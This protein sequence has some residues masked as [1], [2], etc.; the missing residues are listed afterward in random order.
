MGCDD[1]GGA[2]GAF[3][4]K[5]RISADIRDGGITARVGDCVGGGDGEDADAA[6]ANGAGDAVTL[7][8]NRDRRSIRGETYTPSNGFVRLCPPN[9]QTQLTPS[10]SIEFVDSSSA[11]VLEHIVVIVRPN[12]DRGSIRGETYTISTFFIG[13]CPQNIRPQLTPTRP[14]EFVDT[15]PAFSGVRISRSP[16]ADVVIIRPNRNHRSIRGKTYTYSTLFILLRPQ[17]IRSQLTP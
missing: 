12:R 17:Y 2:V 16:A 8:P 11:V 4:E 3:D 10:R 1:I 14:I 9:I 13:L 6:Y 7:R 15:S 5:D